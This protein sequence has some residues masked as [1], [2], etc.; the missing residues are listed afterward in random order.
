MH[1]MSDEFLVIESG[2]ITEGGDPK[3]PCLGCLTTGWDKTSEV[4]K[5]DTAYVYAFNAT[6]LVSTP[7]RRHAIRPGEYGRFAGPA[8]FTNTN[9]T[10]ENGGHFLAVKN[11][12]SGTTLKGGPIEQTGRLRYID[13]C[14]D[15]LLLPPDKYGDPCLNHLHFP[16]GIDQTMHIHPSAR[17]GIVA[18][19]RGVAITPDNEYALIPGLA[20]VITPDGLHR[21]RTEGETMD[22]IAFHPESDFGPQDD[23]HPMVN[24]T[25]VDG[26]SAAKIKSIRTI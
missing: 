5:G 23:D 19:G 3:H 24:R 17:I 10:E 9:V 8:K 4:V 21:F 26:V 12:H 22:V 2:Q 11:N 1:N 14:T 15:S 18:R 13:G 25:I 7:T 20:F 16:Q 6:V